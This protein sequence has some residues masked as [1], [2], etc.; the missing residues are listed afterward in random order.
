MKVY[1]FGGASVRNAQG[2]RNLE[3][4]VRGETELFII[5]SAMGK[6]TNA[7]ERVFD[8]FRKGDRP[9]ANDSIDQIEIS[10]RE[11]IDDLFGRKGYRIDKVDTLFSDLRKYISAAS[12]ESTKAEQ[13]YDHIVAFGELISTSI[14]S[15]YL[16]ASGIRNSWI[17]MRKAFLTQSRHK[18]AN[19]LLEESKPLLLREMAESDCTVFVG[20]GF[21]G[22]APDGT[23]TTLGREGSDY[24]AA[25]VANLTNA[26][27]MSV[28]K[29]VDGIL[30]ADPRIF[31]DAKKIDSLNYV[32]AIELAY[33]GAQII[34]PKTIK[35]L[36]NKLIPLYVRP[37]G[38]KNA[39]GTAIVEDAPNVSTPII[40]LK[41]N[42][43]LLTL[44]SK[45][46]SFVLEEKFPVVF[47]TLER[48]RIKTNLI[49]NTAVHLALCVEESWHI[50]DLAKALEEEGF[51]VKIN[52]SVELL[53]IRHYDDGAY[54]KY[55]QRKE[56]LV[57]QTTPTTVR[58]VRESSK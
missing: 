22:S 56:C 25:V 8:A 42:Q 10:H 33:S 1:K 49:H 15:R 2:V 24:S 54:M 27:S 26:E 53:T 11:I 23:T 38:D 58:I 39:R 9:A 52:R 3:S 44:A 28:W 19:V 32:D 4:I 29:D 18:D 46:L 13:H 55:A 48:F 51:E 30:N 31:P 12:F 45:D 43:T 14:V 5:V 50:D 7:L 40:I 21:I 17:D 6:T 57:R 35:P 16:N 34:H 37:F 47:F 36:Q 20:Q 41:K